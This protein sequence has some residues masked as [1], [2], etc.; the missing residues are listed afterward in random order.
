MNPSLVIHGPQ[1]CGKTVNGQRLARHFGLA[2]IMDDE[3][4]WH[5]PIPPGTLVLTNEPPP[6]RVA[7]T[8]RVMSFAEAMRAA[9]FARSP[10]TS[11]S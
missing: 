10:T 9:G 5:F 7:K 2:R 1:G 4:Q 11:T 3:W 6:A 8:V